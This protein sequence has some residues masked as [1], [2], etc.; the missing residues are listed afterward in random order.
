MNGPRELE[1]RGDS[2]ELKGSGSLRAQMEAHPERFPRG[3]YRE[4]QK[5]RTW[6]VFLSRKPTKTPKK[7]S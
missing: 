4:P 1:P 6:L 2:G 3:T 5:G 7:Q